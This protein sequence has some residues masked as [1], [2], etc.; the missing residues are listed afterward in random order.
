VISFYPFWVGDLM[1][2]VLED[3]GSPAVFFKGSLPIFI[4]RIKGWEVFLVLF[5]RLVSVQKKNGSL[6]S[7]LQLFRLSR[8]TLASFSINSASCRIIALF[9]VF[10]Y[11]LAKLATKFPNQ[12]LDFR[13]VL[14]WEIIKGSADL[15]FSLV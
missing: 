11:F 9:Q 12:F 15:P 13:H 7:F 4:F 6:L 2:G 10:H 5:L 8:P 1:L 14:I 3:V